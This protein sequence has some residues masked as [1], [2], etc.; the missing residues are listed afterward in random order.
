[1]LVEPIL[2]GVL[3]MTSVENMRSVEEIIT[4]IEGFYPN[5]S[6]EKNAL[7]RHKKALKFHYDIVAED[8]EDRHLK[9]LNMVLH[10]KKNPKYQWKKEEFNEELEDMGMIHMAK[11]IESTHAKC[12]QAIIKNEEGEEELKTMSHFAPTP[13]CFVRPFGGRKSDE[14]KA[15]EH[16]KLSDL[17][18]DLK[19][20]SIED[21][22]TSFKLKK[23]NFTTLDNRYQS[24]RNELLAAMQEKGIANY[25]S[26]VG[27]FKVVKKD[28]EYDLLSVRGAEKIVKEFVY[29]IRLVDKDSETFEIVDSFSKDKIVTYEDAFTLN[30]HHVSF[31]EEGLHI[32]NVLVSSITKDEVL[33][34]CSRLKEKEEETKTKE[35]K[36]KTKATFPIHCKV[37]INGETLLRQLPFATGKIENMIDKGYLHPK[38]LDKYRFIEKLEDVSFNFEIVDEATHNQRIEMFLDKNMRRGQTLRYMQE[39][40]RD[41]FKSM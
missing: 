30:Y 7:E 40:A 23:L 21:A 39:N 41:V 8:S 35:T 16:G 18:D 15:R 27:T 13:E 32:D 36:T 3:Y 14:E 5:Y 34:I 11:K 28:P 29:E 4:E 26:D 22:V 9:L 12:L 10:Y 1:M 33:K 37:I 38:T 25:K 6:F 19:G 20:A 31:T 24:L 2:K 17:E